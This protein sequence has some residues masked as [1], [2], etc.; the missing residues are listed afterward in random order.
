LSNCSK[1]DLR[2]QLKTAPKLLVAI[3]ENG[4]LISEYKYDNN[5]R[6]IQANKYYSGD[7]ISLSEYFEYNDQDLLIRK[8][9]GEY[10]EEYEYTGNGNL[11]ALVLHFKSNV[12]GY[13]WMKKTEFQ[14]STG[15]LVKGTRYS[16]NGSL[17]SNLYY[18]YDAKGNTI[19]RT[20]F[21]FLPDYKDLIMSQVKFTYDDK[22]NPG[23]SSR[24]WIRGESLVDITQGNNPT[25]SYYYNIIMSSFPPQYEITYDY[26]QMDL[27]VREFR[28][29]LN[30]MQGTKTYEYEYIEKRK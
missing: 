28:R 12:D 22:I 8:T 26:D 21:S 29:R 3:R 2:Y 6:L 5:N 19:E 20:E 7:T 25:Y 14:Y 10:V 15:R 1:D 24:S 27:P 4:H 30:E 17:M 16:S 11:T 13:S 9:Y 18:K 23:I